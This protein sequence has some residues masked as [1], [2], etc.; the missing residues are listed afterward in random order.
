MQ[1]LELIG[2]LVVAAALVLGAM[3]YFHVTAR[4]ALVE[5]E[6]ERRWRASGGVVGDGT[7]P[8]WSM[9]PDFYA[10]KQP[11]QEKDSTNATK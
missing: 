1:W 3:R 2:G 11:P 4:N 6:L 5:R 9:P 8:P 10:P 7:T